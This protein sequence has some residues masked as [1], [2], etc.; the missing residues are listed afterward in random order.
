MTRHNPFALASKPSQGFHDFVHRTLSQTLLSP[1]AVVLSLWYIRRMAIHTGGGSN[2]S[3]LRH[4]LRIAAQTGRLGGED[5]VQRVLTLGLACSNKWLDDNTFTNKSWSDVTHLELREI[6]RLELLALGPL[7]FDL[8]VNVNEWAEW[9]ATVDRG[10]TPFVTDGTAVS[11]AV[12]SMHR[13]LENGNAKFDQEIV[14][15]GRHLNPLSPASMPSMAQH[16]VVLPP[17]SSV[18]ADSVS[19]AALSEYHYSTQQRSQAYGYTQHGYHGGNGAYHGGYDGHQPTHV[20]PVPPAA[21]SLPPPAMAAS[22]QQSRV[23]GDVF[24][25]RSRPNQQAREQPQRNAYT[26]P[27]YGSDQVSYSGH[28]YYLAQLAS[29][30]PRFVSVLA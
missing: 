16:Q 23:S 24:F 21:S 17:L 25:P 27:S 9:I 4:A 22:Q 20:A 18:V 5:A 12:Q 19:P 8:S 3:Q 14:M 30:Q 2:G 26:R 7:K 28:Q 13:A 29:H 1:T 15:R 11:S 6:N 10:V